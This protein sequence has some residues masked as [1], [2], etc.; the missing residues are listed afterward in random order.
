[1]KIFSDKHKEKKHEFTYLNRIGNWAYAIVDYTIVEER[2]A[3]MKHHHEKHKN[4]FK[5]RS[6][7]RE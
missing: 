7:K 4:L 2:F 3:I 5:G 6:I 1:M